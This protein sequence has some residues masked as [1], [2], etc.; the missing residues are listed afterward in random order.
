MNKSISFEDLVF[1]NGLVNLNA[2][3]ELINKGLEASNK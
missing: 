3:K 2:V 1:E